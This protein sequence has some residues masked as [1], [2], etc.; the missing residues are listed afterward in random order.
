MRLETMRVPKT[1]SERFLLLRRG[2]KQ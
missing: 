1:T 2:V